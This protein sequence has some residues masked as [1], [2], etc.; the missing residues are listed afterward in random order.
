MISLLWD[1]ELSNEQREYVETIRNSGDALL[2]IINEILDFSKIESEAIEIDIQH[3]DLDACI[4][5]SL[6]LFAQRAYD[7]EI[8]L[9]YFIKPGIP[10]MIV[11]DR[12]RLRQILI[13]LIGNAVKFTKEGQ[14][15]VTISRK[16]ESS[17]PSIT[18]FSATEN[19]STRQIQ[20]H[21]TVEDSGI[22]IP[23]DRVHRLFHSFSQVDASTT[24]KYGGTGL[25]LA[26]SKRLVEVM[27]GE[28]WFESELGVG[29][30]FHFSFWTSIAPDW[31][32]SDIPTVP[33]AGC[34]ALLIEDNEIIGNLI[35]AQ[36]KQR[37]INTLSRKSGCEA[38]AM[39]KT[40]V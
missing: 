39:A 16:V 40:S 22:G 2:E 19:A 12:S 29:S 17:R 6:D 35:A 25:G 23:A 21:F 4:V 34:N 10:N 13:N 15:T 3:F 9:G 20:L 28:I 26:I 33:A 1:T 24:R 14:V 27:G 37:G 11:G 31:I 30:K 8:D 36:M 5:D 18:H 7:K 38:N 32:R